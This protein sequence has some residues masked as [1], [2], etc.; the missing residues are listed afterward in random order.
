V[1]IWNAVELLIFIITQQSQFS[2]SISI[3]K[4]SNGVTVAAG[5]RFHDEAAH[6]NAQRHRQLLVT[7]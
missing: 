4:V 6:E 2:I 7:V 5:R 1:I 3:P